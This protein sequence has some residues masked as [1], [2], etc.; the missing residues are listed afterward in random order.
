MSCYA[1]S[2]TN[3][4]APR[5]QAATS[6]AM[7]TPAALADA[8]AIDIALPRHVVRLSVALAALLGRDEGAEGSEDEWLLS[9][10]RAQGLIITCPSPPVAQRRV[11]A[12]LSANSAVPPHAAAAAAG[13]PPGRIFVRLAGA[14]AA[15]LGHAEGADIAEDELLLWLREAELI[16]YPSPLLGG[17]LEFLP[18]VLEREV[19]P[20][21]DPVDRTVLA[22]VARPWLA[23]VVA[24]GL[25]R[26][27][28]SAGVPLKIKEFVGSVERLAWA[29]ANGCPWDSR[30]SAIV[31][32]SGH[33]NVLQWAR[34][35]ACPWDWVTC[36]LAAWR[37]QRAMLHFAQSR[38]ISW[39]LMTTYGTGG[40]KL[41]V[42][43]CLT[44]APEQ[45]P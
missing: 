7:Q 35:H 22:Q 11:P 29:K 40:S 6:F 9:L 39:L 24:S 32:L 42:K 26:A 37:G 41:E 31:A 14:L 44:W 36:C 16:T 23:A 1:L 3:P 34:E 20:R 27:G 18:E 5:S 4:P 45:W 13:R 19:L 43:Q 12:A 10:L 8:A 21:L 25:I 2:L 30:T 28:K 15:L 33:L 17:M 38:G